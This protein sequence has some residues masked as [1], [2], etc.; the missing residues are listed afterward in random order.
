MLILILR[1]N[2]LCDLLFKSDLEKNH[3]DVIQKRI[4]NKKHSSKILDLVIK[5]KN[6]I[7][8]TVIMKN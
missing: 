8:T 1:F 2:N 5:L 3:N 4:R 6:E 7:I